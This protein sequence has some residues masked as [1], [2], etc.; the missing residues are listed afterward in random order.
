MDINRLLE[1]VELEEDTVILVDY[2]DLQNA[3]ADT[4]ADLATQIKTLQSEGCI[5]IKPLDCR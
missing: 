3:D 1:F 4:K 5:V 2:H